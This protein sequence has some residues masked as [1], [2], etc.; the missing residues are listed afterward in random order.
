M[1]CKRNSFQRLHF[2]AMPPINGKGGLFMCL[3][4][5]FW[6]TAD[7]CVV[8]LVMNCL[9]LKTQTPPRWIQQYRNWS[10]SHSRRPVHQSHTGCHGNARLI[11]KF[12]N[13]YFQFL[14]FLDCR[15]GTIHIPALI[16]HSMQS[17]FLYNNVHLQENSLLYPRHKQ[18]L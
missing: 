10:I 7:Q 15:Q 13:A 1:F 8:L 14:H 9:L 3:S 5:C 11:E 2:I 12:L 17:Y 18:M 4:T 16:V 6:L